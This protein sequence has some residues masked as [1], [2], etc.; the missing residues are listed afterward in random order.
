MDSIIRNYK[1][2]L[3][4]NRDILLIFKII[5]T[6]IAILIFIM[7]THSG[8]TNIADVVD[9][10][11]VTSQI[12]EYDTKLESLVVEANKQYEQITEE[13]VFVE[14]SF[15]YSDFSVIKDGSAKLYKYGSNDNL[16]KDKTICI[17]AGHGKKN[18]EKLETYS[19]PDMTPKVTGGTNAKGAV[20]SNA[21]SQGTVLSNKKTESEVNLQIANFLKDI[22]LVKGYNVLMIRED[23]NCRLDNV[24]RTVLANQYA[25]IHISIHFDS[26]TTD[27]GIFYVKAPNIKSYIEM[28]PVKST[29]KKSEELG[30]VIID[31]YRSMGEKIFNTGSMGLDLTQISYST[32]PTIDLELG[33]KKTDVDSRDRLYSF[34]EGLYYGIAN[35]YGFEY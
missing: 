19:H 17:N 11:E 13:D 32:I 6:Y 28:E 18:S 29:Y 14:D 16:R 25:D 23:E 27:K 9:N 1:R 30:D 35:Y 20:K 24:A 4:D 12:I 33:D 26:T 7:I 10:N 21:I 34:A 8:C 15:L 5:I 31:A 3:R 22:L 2:K